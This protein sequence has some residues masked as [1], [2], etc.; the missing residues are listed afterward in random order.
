MG[1]VT[2]SGRRSGVLLTLGI[3]FISLLV[4]SLATL[5]LRNAEDSDERLMEL[6]GYDRVYNIDRA[7]SDAYRTYDT[8]VAGFKII[9]NDTKLYIRKFTDKA[10][11]PEIVFMAFSKIFFSFY[12]NT[13]Y[14]STVLH[15]LPQIGDYGLTFERHNS[16]Q[17]IYYRY[18]YIGNA[19]QVDVGG[20][21]VNGSWLHVLSF[22]ENFCNNPGLLPCNRGSIDT[23]EI[24]Y[25]ANISKS[26]NISDFRRAKCTPGGSG[27]G[28]VKF[29][30]R[31]INNTGWNICVPPFDAPP[32]PACNTWEDIVVSGDTRE[33]GFL[34]NIF[35]VENAATNNEF[36]PAI[37][38]GNISDSYYYNPLGTFLAVG[39]G[40]T[41]ATIT[42]D[43]NISGPEQ[44]R[45]FD[46]GEAAIM[47][48]LGKRMR[49]TTWNY[50]FDPNVQA[51]KR[52]YFPNLRFP[53]R[54]I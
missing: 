39:I 23:V 16:S 29:R 4:L 47:L 12:L 48:D 3:T 37:M 8:D 9:A 52:I 1:K 17:N 50:D 31:V 46:V 36:R 25:Q 45:V 49:V 42:I 21:L 10:N 54:I 33:S 22:N 19:S 27:C 2:N 26:L 24:T 7:I 6:A 38:L 51:Y 35:Y 40:N 53:I 28:T 15:T 41:T 11:D 44:M 43:I 18:M 34:K 30:L 14:N 20:G 13:L 5:I 32:S